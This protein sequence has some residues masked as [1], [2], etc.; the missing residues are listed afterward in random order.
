VRGCVLRFLVWRVSGEPGL[1]FFD[2]VCGFFADIADGLEGQFAGEIVCGVFGG[3]F[4][5][6]G[7][8]LSSIE[9]LGQDLADVAVVG[10]VVVEVVVEF[11]GDVGELLEEIVS[12]L[13]AAGFAGT[14]EEILNRLVAGVEELDEDKDAI[15][16][17]VGGVAQLLDLALREGTLAALGVE[18][19]NECEEN[20]GEREPAEH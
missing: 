7:P 5:V 20:E 10:A 2:E 4:E 15:A 14:G 3:L 11:V 13:F 9:K 12:V 8:A 19:Q 17:V 18:G 16:G 6:G 1:L